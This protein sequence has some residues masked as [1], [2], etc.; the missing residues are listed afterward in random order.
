MA[1]Q[2]KG[3]V[4]QQTKEISEPEDPFSCNLGIPLYTVSTRGP[5]TIFD[6]LKQKKGKS[7]GQEIICVGGGG[8]GKKFGLQNA[9][10]F[11][12]FSKENGLK[13]W[14]T[15]DI[16]GEQIVTNLVLHPAKEILTAFYGSGK[17][18]KI[19]R[20]N[21]IDSA[22]QQ[23][24]EITTIYSEDEDDEQDVVSLNR[25]GSILATSGGSDFVVRLWNWETL[26]SITELHGHTSEIVNIDFSLEDDYLITC[27]SNECKIWKEAKERWECVGT[28]TPPNTKALPKG[29]SYEFSK[30]K[31]CT[32]GNTLHFFTLQTQRRA[33]SYITKWSVD[34][35]KEI[36]TVVAHRKHHGSCAALAVSPNGK[37]VA[38]GTSDG[39]IA[40]WNTETLDWFFCKTVHGFFVSEL[41]FNRDSDYL[42]SICGDYSVKAT[43]VDN[44]RGF[45]SAHGLNIFY[46][47]LAVFYCFAL[48]WYYFGKM[49]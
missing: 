30:A 17:K 47:I 24:D 5:L 16:E 18:C 11:F 3:K 15:H 6:E 32:S 10:F 48:V 36:K 34:N 37:F 40:M 26:E 43:K 23:Q 1:T 28:I 7:D 35:L 25:S 21:G 14:F 12:K 31:F 4:A 27:S 33:H 46:V 20:F 19:L 22:P 29:V 45:V 44:N 13:K 41:E 9:M 38:T 42:I 49:V 8:G 2:R 39:E